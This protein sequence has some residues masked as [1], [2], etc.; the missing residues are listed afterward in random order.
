MAQKQLQGIPTADALL[1]WKPRTFP[2]FQLYAL[3][4]MLL[5][6]GLCIREALELR[7]EEIDFENLL[8]KVRGKGQSSGSFRCRLN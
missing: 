6:T 2:D 1:G 8:V 4:R 7:R 3:M 5:D